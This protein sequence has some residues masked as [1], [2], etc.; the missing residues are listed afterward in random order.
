[1]SKNRISVKIGGQSGQGINTT[2]LLLAKTLNDYGYEIFS[3][4]EYPSL[5]TGGIASYQ[6]DFANKEV[7]SSSRHCNILLA[8][9][10]ESLNEYLNDLKKDS[11]IIHDQ[12]DLVFTQEQEHLLKTKNI[13][14]IFL[15]A[16]NIATQVGG[17]KIMSNAV[18][19]GF[20]WQ[21]FDL[22]VDPLIKIILE[23]FKKKNVDLEA[24]QKCI[25]AGYN[26]PAFRPVLSEKLDIPQ[27]EIFKQSSYVMTG[28]HAISLGAIAAGVRA[29]YGYPM[30]PATSIFKYL[31]NTSEKTGVLVKQAENEIT[32]I[33]LALGSMYMGTR[34][35][36]ATSG[37]G[38]DL[39]TETISCAGISETPLVIVLG[40][41]AG[42][43][44]GVPTWT[45][46]GD[47]NVALTGGHGEFPRCV[48]A[49]SDAKSS[50]TLTQK[51]FN[52]GEKYQIPVVLLTEKQ[53][54]ESL[55][56]LKNLP[57][58]IPIER[59]L[60]EDLSGDEKR[61]QI[62]DSGISPRWV[63]S[64]EK[65][66]YLNNSD[67]HNEEGI[68]TEVSEQIINMS[69]KR[70]RKLQSLLRDIPEPRLYGDKNP[71]IVLVG[72]GSVKNSVLDAIEILHNDSNM[73]KKIKVGYLHYEYM[74]PLKTATLQK[75]L[76]EEKRIVLIENNQT[77][78]LGQLIKKETGYEF[79]EKLLKYNARPFFVEDILDFLEI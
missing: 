65:S 72:W 11:I 42:P 4:R 49:A 29:Y 71:E 57:K 47:L 22:E 35:L 1:M 48:L 7:K 38:F 24:E 53:I 31:G 27:T 15:D 51:A 3:Y 43:G 34:A 59:G 40:Q 39:M 61:Y 55:F 73:Q 33:Q 58:D 69:G 13:T 41:R 9:T 44:T 10:K 52:I 6:I 66:P 64:K 68:S 63:P 45:G 18:M 56:S 78:Q 50:Y 75:L 19:L 79:K 20:L 60:K 21:I 8:F 46:S 77:G 14:P 30:T 25:K 5:I 62:T 36:V 23:H 26:S 17:T 67:E 12:A 32:A 70:M 2:G 28:N 54:A 16:Q 37:G 76:E 74:Y